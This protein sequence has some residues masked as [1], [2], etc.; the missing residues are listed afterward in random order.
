MYIEPGFRVRA[1][2]A[3]FVLSAATIVGLVHATV[4]HDDAAPCPQ[5]DQACATT[6]VGRV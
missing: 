6:V 4:D 1:M 2:L 3:A 5:L